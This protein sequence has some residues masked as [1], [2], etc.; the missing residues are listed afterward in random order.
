[1]PSVQPSSPISSRTCVPSPNHLP[2]MTGWDGQRERQRS[3]PRS[4]TIPRAL[5][6]LLTIWC[7]LSTCRRHCNIR[8]PRPE[9]IWRS[10]WPDISLLPQDKRLPCLL[11]VERR[12]D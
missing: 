11:P 10:C 2:Q 7:N 4:T 1:M 9:T 12:H 3:T 8:L 5:P 6:L